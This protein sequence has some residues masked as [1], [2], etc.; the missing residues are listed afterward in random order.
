[1][2]YT[3]INIGLLVLFSGLLCTSC[4]ED[5]AVEW[6]YGESVP[7]GIEELRL[8][9]TSDTRA[10]GT[11]VTTNGTTIAVFLTNTGGYT[12]MYNKT[13]TYSGGSWSSTDDIYVDKRSGKALGVYD[14][15]GLVSFGTNS[16]ATTTYLEAQAY[17]ENKLWYYDNTN[18]TGV[19]SSTPAVFSMKCAYARLMLS[20]KR[21]AT[22]YVSG[23]CNITDVNIKH[24]SGNNFFTS[25]TLDISTGTYGGS[26]TADGWTYTLNTGDITAGATNTSYDVLVPPQ[27]VSDGL[28][29][30]LTID[31]VNRAVTVPAAKFSNNLSAGAQYTIEL[32][33]TDTTITMSGSVKINDFATGKS[34]SSEGE[35]G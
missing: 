16:T 34:T 24:S 7:L 21:H 15:N 13:Y 32:V 14:P 22:N 20:I 33:I 35:V 12:P 25:S 29:I 1:M 2:K 9:G 4:S 10:G 17:D 5:T 26:A 3:R 18:G 8:E 28:T 27:P 19:N 11:P 30:T 31:N 6:S 23:N